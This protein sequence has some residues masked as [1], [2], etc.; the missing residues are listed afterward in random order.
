MALVADALVGAVAEAVEAVLPSVLGR[1]HDPSPA[2]INPFGTSH[3]L[4]SPAASQS[5]HPSDPPAALQQLFPRQ[6]PE[7][8]SASAEQLLPASGRQMNA[9]RAPKMAL[10][11]LMV[12]TATP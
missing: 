5:R 9:K 1:Q 12:Q 7:W 6:S 3:T 10:Q 11:A 2:A 4:Q 8:H